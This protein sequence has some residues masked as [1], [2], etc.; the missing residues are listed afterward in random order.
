MSLCKAPAL[1]NPQ[2]SL[3]SLLPSATSFDT[4]GIPGHMH[5]K[6]SSIM[7]CMRRIKGMDMEH[8]LQRDVRGSEGTNE[9]KL[10]IMRG[11]G[12]SHVQDMGQG[13]HK[14]RSMRTAVQNCVICKMIRCS[15]TKKT[16]N[17]TVKS[18]IIRTCF[19]L[20]WI[21]SSAFIGFETKQWIHWS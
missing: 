11:L 20:F 12:M 19:S 7:N 17:Y 14:N 8:T 2:Y 10:A 15:T 18:D 6:F 5:C 21:Y 9:P 3:I 13:A 16:K 1:S 4:Q